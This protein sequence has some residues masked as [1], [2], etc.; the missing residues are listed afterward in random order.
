MLSVLV[1]QAL[2]FELCLVKNSQDSCPLEIFYPFFERSR[3]VILDVTQCISKKFI[4]FLKK[5]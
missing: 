4:F 3:D 5:K 1:R 2:R